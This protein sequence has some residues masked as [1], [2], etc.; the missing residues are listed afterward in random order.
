MGP[1]RAD[2]LP[3]AEE[4]SGKLHAPAAE[5]V[6]CPLRIALPRLSM[7]TLIEH[8]DH[9]SEGYL[10]GNCLVL[11]A[12]HAPSAA[13]MPTLIKLTGAPQSGALPEVLLYWKIEEQLPL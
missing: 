12:A 9:F 4:V 2:R 3:P 1:G 6:R 7:P 5:E 8:A 11:L 13:C 10:T